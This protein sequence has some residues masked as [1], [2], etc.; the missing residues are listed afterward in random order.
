MNNN[1]NNKKKNKKKNSLNHQR[2]LLDDLVEGPDVVLGRSIRQLL[3][4]VVEKSGDGIDGE[5]VHRVDDEVV[6]QTNKTRQSTT[7]TPLVG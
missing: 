2:Y 3:G 1:N 6:G 7:V 4:Q 5:N